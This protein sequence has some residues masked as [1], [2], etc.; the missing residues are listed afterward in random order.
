LHLLEVV[1]PVPTYQSSA[2]LLNAPMDVDASWDEDAESAAQAHV[3]ALASR[4]KARGL[5][6]QAEALMANQVPEAINA[7]AA[8]H[9]CDLIV[10]SSHAHTG[11][12]RMF[13]GSVTD[14][15]VRAASRPVLVIRRESDPEAEVSPSEQPSA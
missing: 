3:E 15:V 10:M 14:A 8:E 13:L 9:A 2:L 11:P 7:N 5:A 1:Q 6:V 12:A 4:L